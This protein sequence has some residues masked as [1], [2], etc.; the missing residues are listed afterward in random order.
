MTIIVRDCNAPLQSMD[1]SP[2]QKVNNKTVSLNNLLNQMDFI[3]IYRT[4][5]PK[6]TEYMFFSSAHGISS[7]IDHM[8]RYKRSFNKLKEIELIKHLF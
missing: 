1:R 3:G 5:Y 6:P 4:F 7:R 2:R 8:L